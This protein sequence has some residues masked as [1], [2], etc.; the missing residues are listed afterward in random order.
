MHFYAQYKIRCT[1]LIL[2]LM[3]YLHLSKLSDQVCSGM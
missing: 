2:F 3:Y 1:F